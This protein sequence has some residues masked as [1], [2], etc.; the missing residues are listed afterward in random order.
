MKQDIVCG[1]DVGDDT[2]FTTLHGGRKMF[3]CSHDC[4]QKFIKDPDHF[5]KAGKA[6]TAGE[7]AQKKGSKAA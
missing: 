7:A 5:V 2:K 6:E 4:Q 1:M 3:F